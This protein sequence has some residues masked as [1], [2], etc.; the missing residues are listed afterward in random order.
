VESNR[1]NFTNYQVNHASLA[2]ILCQ[3]IFDS[4]NKEVPFTVLAEAPA[5]SEVCFLSK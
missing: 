1:V 4:N 5:S 3:V 2:F